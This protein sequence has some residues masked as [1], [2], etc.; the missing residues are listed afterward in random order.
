MKGKI[1]FATKGVIFKGDKVLLLLKSKKEDVNPNT[2]DIP[3]GRLEFGEMP[4]DALKRE[5]MGETGLEVDVKDLSRCWSFIKK[6][7]NF[8]LVGVTFYCEFKSGNETLSGEHIKIMWIKASE[9]LK[10][11]YPQWLKDETAAA[12]ALKDGKT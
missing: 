8:Q 7:E 2:V 6:E 10:G 5:I 11:D 1:G 9:I 3:G 12:L 4:K